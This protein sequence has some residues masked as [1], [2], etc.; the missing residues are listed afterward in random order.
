MQAILEKAKELEKAYNWLLAADCYQQA[1]HVDSATV[2]STPKILE[3]LGLCYQLASRQ[4]QNLEEF[5]KLTKQAVK[6]YKNAAELLE[7]QNQPENQGKSLELYALAEYACSW[8]AS[9]PSEKKDMLNKSCELTRRSLNAYKSKNNEV[10]YGRTSNHLLTCLFDRLYVA[11]DFEEVRN[12]GQEAM[13]YADEAITVLSKCKDKEG[14][15]RAY[16]IASLVGWYMATFGEVE[17]KAKKELAEKTIYYSERALEL[18]KEVDNSYYGALSDW[19][20]TLSALL[21]T[22][23]AEL[24]LKYAQKTLEHGTYVKDNY[25]KGV[26][27]YL[28]AFVTDWMMVREADPDRKKEGSRKIISYSEDAIRCLETVDQHLFIAETCMFYAE[29]YFTLGQDVETSPEERQAALEKGVS[30]GRKGLEHAILSGSLDATGSTLHA[31]SKA[32]HFYSN[33]ETR[34]TEKTRLLQE[35]LDCRKEVD[36]IIQKTFPSNDWLIGVN[37][38]Y[39]VL[40]EADLAKVEIDYNKKKLLLESA[41]SNMEDGISHCKRWISSRPVPTESARAGTLGAFED[42]LGTILND[43]YLLAKEKTTLDKAVKTHEDA[44]AQFKKT[45]MPTRVAESYWKI[46]RDQNR[47]GE[48]QKAAANFENA[49]AQYL[50]SAKSI[51]HFAEF[52]KEH[53]L[54]MKAWCEIEKANLAH[55]HEDYA[56]AMKHY[57]A[58]ATFLQQTKSWCY[59]SSDFFAWSLLEQAEDLS[60]K[61]KSIESMET[62]EKAAESFKKAKAASG[63]EIDKMQNLDEKEMAIGLNKA[64]VRRKEYCLARK[65]VEEARTLDRKG[66]H[67]QSADKY[68]SAADAFGEMLKTTEAEADR[69]EIEPFYYMCRA[70]YKMKMADKSASPE[71]YREASNLFSQAKEH[72]TKDRTTLLVSGNTAFCKALEH[73]TGFEATREREHFLKTKQYLESAADYY[74]RAGFDNASKWTNATEM[75]FDAYN[76]MIMAEVEDDPQKKTKTY[77]LAE[78]CLERSVTLYEEAGYIS[79]K[80]EVLKTLRKVAEKR[81]FALSLG[82]LFTAPDDALSPRA[83]SAPHLTVEE[84]VGLDKF[85]HAFLQANLIVDKKE[86]LIG[87]SLSLEVQLANSGKDS[88]FLTRAEDMFPVGFDIIEK[89]EKC[90]VDDSF[91]NLKGRKLA[92]LETGEIK[93]KLRP[94]KKG[95][96]TFAPT[97]QFMDEAGEQK[98]FKLEQVTINVKEMG[99]RSWLRGQ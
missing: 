67:S 87:E 84:P 93:L 91:L 34:K 71:L 51:P 9:T 32:L 29:C 89:P 68:D 83:I 11:S 6:T 14:L 37:K 92:P 54:Y 3:R 18:A 24:A 75:L 56:G 7:K 1:L 98:S 23:K 55:E 78:K 64:S 79:K 90:V 12:V 95:E 39:Q 99:I 76:Y 46:A 31:L 35:A 81:E 19:A 86:M 41:V 4:T 94:R 77:L 17:E 43:L 36:R 63:E 59:L 8:L 69:K 33:V 65:D 88:A 5:K 97:I 10:D 72:S 80:E 96:F 62:F 82:K 45:D 73:G 40:I 58:T 48:Y 42:E 27:F 61:E 47:L 21:F 22:E 52:Y 16:S 60:R 13:D 53:A 49:S 66:D 50:L 38:N 20:A 70:W 28:L 85:K 25:L 30:I 2:L 44:A 57:D 15:L 74:L 26:A